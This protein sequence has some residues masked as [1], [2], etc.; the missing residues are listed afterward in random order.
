MDDDER[1]ERARLS[2]V[3]GALVAGVAHARSIADSEVMAIARRYRRHEYLRGL[4]VPRL[5]VSKV[6][7]EL[8]VLLDGVIPSQKAKIASPDTVAVAVR[9]ALREAVNDF[10]LYTQ[11]HRHKMKPEVLEQAEALVE[12]LRRPDSSER[13]ETALRVQLRQITRGLAKGSSG[14]VALSDII[15]RDEVGNLT[16][17]LLRDHLAQLLGERARREHEAA[18]AAMHDDDEGPVAFGVDFEAPSKWTRAQQEEAITAA[19]LTDAITELVADVR[20][21]GEE[22]SILQGTQPADFLVRVDTEEIKNAGTPG[23]VTRIRLTLTEEGLEWSGEGDG[24]G[25]SRWKLTP[26]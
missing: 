19:M 11:T 2:D 13:F 10:V 6:V 18:S 4:S 24:D 9:H 15:I 3:L 21:A 12:E 20:A 14:R 25:G 8:P 7:V 22:A 16:E 5:R 26:E 1:E 17:R 23:A